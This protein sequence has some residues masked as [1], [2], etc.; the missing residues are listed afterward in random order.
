MIRL[1]PHTLHGGLLLTGLRALM[2]VPA[3][4]YVGN[5]S[6]GRLVATAVL[7][8]GTLTI[9]Q[10]LTTKLLPELSPTAL[11]AA[12]IGP[13]AIPAGAQQV[14]FESLHAARVIDV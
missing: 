12:G 6:G 13:T 3:L 14:S 4:K 5:V 8:G 2:L 11:P 10:A 9:A 7:A 1:N